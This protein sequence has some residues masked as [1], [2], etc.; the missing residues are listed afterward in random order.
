MLGLFDD[1]PA[2]TGVNTRIVQLA[3]HMGNLGIEVHLLVPR[4]KPQENSPYYMKEYN[5][6]LHEIKAFF[7]GGRIYPASLKDQLMGFLRLQRHEKFDVVHT[8][9]YWAGILGL[10][11]RYMSG[12]SV[13]FD[14]QDWFFSYAYGIS[15]VGDNLE[16]FC[17]GHSDVTLVLGERLRQ[18]LILRGLDA[19]KVHVIPNGVEEDFIK[20]PARFDEIASLREKL[21][22]DETTRIVIHIGSILYLQGIDL[23]IRAIAKL[24]KSLGVRLIIVGDGPERPRLQDLSHKLRTSN[25]VIF[26][27]W[28][29]RDMLRVLLDMADIGVVAKRH[30]NPYTDWMYPLKI[31][32]YFARGKAVL[33]TNL[34]G[35]ADVVRDGVNGILVAPDD[36]EAMCKGLAMLLSDQSACAKMGEKGKKLV[37]N[38]YRWK[39][40]AT[41]L[42]AIY[43]SIRKK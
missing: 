37:M 35:T 5:A 31:L 43:E 29:S 24:K 3:K 21:G 4:R 27:G 12:V 34:S 26:T 18:L 39:K 11:L 14:P 38:K 25:D 36:E 41:D 2:S 32:D 30:L 19:K 16:A 40:I 8:H 1:F 28:V 42:K 9:L 22:I 15:F 17:A 13:V 23:V 7:P 6:V 20:T 33:A 10:A